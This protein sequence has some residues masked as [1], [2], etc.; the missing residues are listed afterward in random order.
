MRNRLLIFAFALLG[1]IS[2]IGCSEFNEAPVADPA[3]TESFLT[4][5]GYVLAG[6]EGNHLQVWDFRTYA[7]Y[8]DG[9]SG[10]VHGYNHILDSIAGASIGLGTSSSFSSTGSYAGAGIGVTEGLCELALETVYDSAFVCYDLPPDSAGGTI[11]YYNRLSGDHCAGQE[12]FVSMDSVATPIAFL[13]N[14][15]I[16]AQQHWA[17]RYGSLY[18]RSDY[19]SSSGAPDSPVIRH[20]RLYRLWSTQGRRYVGFRLQ[21][22]SAYRY[23]YLEITTQ[24]SHINIHRIVIER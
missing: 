12:Y 7:M 11:T 17:S 24:Q 15:R 23:G 5:K 18:S 16:D 22:G 3:V 14:Q 20:N 19:I 8:V 4:R 21:E 10:Q 6:E 2:L 13:S 9:E 1:M